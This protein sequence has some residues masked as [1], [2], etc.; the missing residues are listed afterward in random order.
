MLKKVGSIF[1]LL[2]LLVLAACSG[3]SITDDASNEEN[4]EGAKNAEQ[5]KDVT[6]WFYYT[7]KQ[8]ELFLEALDEYNNA[9]DVYEVKGEYVPFPDIKKQLS[10]GLAGGT[11]PDMVQMDVVDNAAFAEQGVLEDITSLVE[12]W[13]EADSFYEGPLQSVTYND[14]Y[15][16][17]P[18]GSNAL[19]LFYNVDMFEEA[20]VEPP[21]TWDELI[22]T[23]E[24]LTDSDQKGFAISAVKSEEG[25]FQFYPF[26]RSAG[27]EY[28]EL[29]SDEAVKSLELLTQLKE[30]GSMGSDVVNATQDDLARQF[31]QEKLA[32]M[33]NGPWNIER[34][35]EENP[36]LN[37]A[38]TQIPKDEQ[39][40][41][42]LGGE[43]L[44]IIKDS[45]VEGAFDF[46]TWFLEADRTETFSAET[47]VFP[48]RKD[49]LENSDFWSDDQHLSGFVPIM[50]VADPRGPSP[51]WPEISEAIQIALQEAL[52]GTKTPAEALDDAQQKVDKILNQ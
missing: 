17:L 14:G 21:A 39:F 52:T 12:E 2:L 4:D 46:L 40:A 49:A 22:K 43:N 1:L 20:G 35:K 24:L 28:T 8:Q 32:M 38:I 5:Q 44:V 41:S 29:S 30:D 42:A 15:Y 34:L 50:D 3:D 25:A 6:I 31:G 48:A 51:Q 36:D 45:N 27:A 47:A 16:G 26:L 7:G 19:G 10:V 18:V 37:F 11:L 13:G 33:V 23:A 9:Q